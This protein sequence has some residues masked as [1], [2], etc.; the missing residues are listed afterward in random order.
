MYVKLIL[1]NK[2]KIYLIKTYNLISQWIKKLKKNPK[3]SDS[4]LVL[5][6]TTL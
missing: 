4:I 2:A 1:I 3:D 6:S 5:M